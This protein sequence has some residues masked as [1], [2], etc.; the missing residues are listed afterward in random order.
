VTNGTT[1]Y[2]VVAASNASGSS[3]NSAQVLATPVA[4]VLAAPTGLTATAGNASVTLTWTAVPGAT[5]YSVKRSTVSGGPYAALATTSAATLTDASVTNGTTYYYVVAASNASRTSAYSSQ[6]SATP[7]ASIAFTSSATG[8]PSSV[9]QGT[10]ATVKATVTCTAGSLANGN[11]QIYIL[12]PNGN[13]TALQNFSAQNF[14]AQQSLAYSMTF[15]PSLAGTYRLEVGVFNASWQMLY[16]NWQAGSMT[17]TPS[18]PS[19]AFTTSAT[20]PSR[21]TTGATAAI[22]VTVTETGASGLSNGNVE[23]Q[24]FNSAGTAVATTYWSAQ[25]FSKG[26]SHTYSYNWTPPANLPAGTY[27]VDVG[28]FNT[29]WSTDYY[30]NTDST[31]AVTQPAAAPT[32]K[33][34]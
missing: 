7:V 20:I 19:V 24:V 26:Q 30:W 3:A 28:V 6:V 2:Y 17:I 13:E 31:V 5:S 15:I 29:A 11:I 22:S 9:A 1:Y 23:L 10:S 34:H 12:D 4:P 33:G 18:V 25:N 8:S 27:S 21:V 32:T 16:W 14:Q